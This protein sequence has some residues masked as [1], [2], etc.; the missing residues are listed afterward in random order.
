MKETSIDV[1]FKVDSE[2]PVNSRNNIERS[3]DTT[4]AHAKH[5]MFSTKNDHTSLC[6]AFDKLWSGLL[7]LMTE[8]EYHVVEK[9]ANIRMNN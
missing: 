8:I 3:R 7:K 5:N 6:P 2:V 9:I 1:F 4:M